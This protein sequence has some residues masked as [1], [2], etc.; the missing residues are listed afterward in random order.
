MAKK[1]RK[2]SPTRLS[3]V[4]FKYQKLVFDNICRHGGGERAMKLGMEDALL[5]GAFP[6]LLTPEGD[7]FWYKV[8]EGKEPKNL[9]VEVEESVKKS[10][11]ITNKHLSTILGKRKQNVPVPR[12]TGS[13]SDEIANAIHAV[14]SVIASGGL[15]L[16]K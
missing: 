6:W 2:L 8:N 11:Q 12:E 7:K 10:E 16:K 9:S 5:S 1:E 14:I 13:P 15:V 3:Q 4:P